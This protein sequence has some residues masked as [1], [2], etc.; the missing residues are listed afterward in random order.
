MRNKPDIDEIDIDDLYNNL[1]VYE[2]EMKKSSTSSSNT[3]NLAFISSENSGS[4]NTVNTAS[5]EHGVS[6]AAG[7]AFTSQVS[8]TPCTH[9]VSCSFFAHPTTSPQL[10]NEDFQQIDGDD[11]REMILR[12][13]WPCYSLGKGHFARECR[14]AKSQGRRPYGDR[15]NA[16][17]TESS[18]KALVAQDGLG[19]YDWS[20]DFEVEP[21]YDTER[22]KH[23]KAKLEIRGYEIALESL[24]ARILG[25]EKNELAWG[26]KYEFQ[27]YDLKCREIKINN[28]NTEL[29]KVVKERD[30]LKLKIE[31]WEGSSKNLT[32]ILNS[33][34]STHDKNGLGFGTQ[35]DDLSN[36]SETDS[37]NSLTVFETPIADISFAGLDE[38]AIRNKIIE[39]KTL[40]TTKTLGNTNDKNA[41]KPKSVNEKVVSKTGFNRDEVIIEDW[42]SDD[43]EDMC[44]VNTVSSVKPNV[45]QADKSARGGGEEVMWMDEWESRSLVQEHAVVDSGCCSHMNWQQS[46]LSDYERFT[47]RLCAFGSDPKG[48]K[49]M[50]KC[51]NKTAKI[52]LDDVY[53]YINLLDESQV[54]LRALK[55]CEYILEFKD[56]CSLGVEGKQHKASCKAKLDRIIRKPLELLHMDLSV[57]VSI[58]SINKK[59]VK[60]WVI[61]ERQRTRIPAKDVVQDA[62]EQPSENASPDKGIQVSEDVFD[63]EGQHQMPE[64]EQVW[65]DELEMMVTQELVA[66]AMNDESRQA[67]ERK[68]VRYA[69]QKKAAQATS[70]NQLSTDRPFVSTDRSNT[71]NV[72]AASTSTCANVD[73]SSFVYF[74]GKIPIDASTLPNVDLPIDPNMPDLEDASDTLP[75]NGIFNRAYDDD[76]DVGAVAD[77]NNMDNQIDGSL[78]QQ[79]KQRDDSTRFLQHK[80]SLEPNTISQALKDESWVEAMQEELLQFKLQQVWILV[81]LPFGKKAIGTKWVFRNKRDERSIVVK[82]KARLVLLRPLHL[83][84]GF[85]SI[86]AWLLKVLFFGINIRR[87]PRAWYETLSSF[88]LENG[89][90]R[91]T[92][93]KTLFIKKNKSDIMLVQVYVDDIIFGSTKKSMCTEFEEVMHKRFQ[94]SSMGELTFFLGLQVK[95][96]PDGIFISQDKYV[97]D[98]LKK[99][100]FCSIKTATTPIES[101]KPLVKDEDGVEVDVHEY[102]SMIGSLMYLTASRPDI[103][104]AVCACARFQ[105]T[106][107]ASHLHAVKRIFR[108]LKHQPKLGL[109]YPRDSPFELEAFSDSD[110]AGASLDRKSTTGGCQFLGRR[111]IS[112]QC[113]KQTIMANSTTEAEYVAAAHC[114]GQVLWIQ[115]QMM[116]YGFNFMNTKI[117]IDNEST[118]C[119]VKNP[120]Y[121][122]RTKHIEIRHHFIRDCYE[123]RLIDVLKI[124]TDSNVADLLTKGFDVTRISMDLRM[125]RCSAGKFYSSMVYLRYAL[126]HNPT[127]YDSLVKQFW[128][129]ATVRTLANGTQQLVAS[130]DSKEYNITEASVRSKLQLA[131]ATGIHNLSDAE[132][133]AGLATLGYVTEG[134]IVP[135]L[136]AML[137]GVAVDQ[138]EGSAQPAEP[139]HTPVD[140]ISSTSQPPIPSLLHQSPPHS[141]PH[142]PPYSPHPSPPLSPPHYSPPGSYEAPLPEGNTSGSAEDSMQLKELMVLVPKL[143]TRIG[144]LE[145]ELKETKQTLGNAVLKLVKKV[146]S[147]ETA[148]KRKSKKVIVSESE[149]E[150]SEDQGRKFQDID[151]DPLVSLVR[152]SMKEKSTDFVT[153]TKASGEAQ[154]EISPTILEAAKTLSKVA[155]QGVSKEKS[156]DKGKRYRRRARSMA[157]K[158]DT[159]LDAREEVNTGR[160]KINTGIEEVSTGSTKIDSGTASKRGQREG[161]A[162]MV[163]EDI[164]ATHKTKEQ[165]RQE[166]AG[167]EE[168]IKLQA[169]LDEEVAKQIHL[170]KM[171]AQRMAEEEAL[172]EQQKKRKAQVQ[173]E[174]QFYT[175]ED[176]DTIRAKLEANAELSKDVLGQDLPEQDFA[177]RMVDMV[178]QRKKHFAEERAKAKRNK[179]MTQSQLR[180]YMSNYLKNQGTWKLSQ[181]KKLKFEEIKEEFDKLVQQIDT[182]VP[183]ATKEKLKRYGEELQTKTSKKQKIND[184]DV[185]AI[186]EKVVEV[187]EEEQ[188]KR[189][190]KRKKQKA[191]KGINVDK[192]AQED[193]ETDK[194]ESVEAMNPTPLTTKSDSVVNWKIFQQGQRSVYQIIRENGAKTVYMSFGAMIKDF[195]REDLIELYRLVMQ[196]YGI[197]RPKDAYDRVLWSDLRT[198]FDP[199]LIEDAIWSLPLQQKMVSWRYYDKCEVHCLTLEACTIYM[200]ADRKYPLSKEACQVMLKMK[201]LDGKMNEVCY[202]LLKMI[203]KQAGIRNCEEKTKT[204]RQNDYVVLVAHPAPFRKFPEPFL[205]LVRMSRYYT[206][207]E[208]TYLSFLHDDKTDMDLFAF[209]QVVNPTKMRVVGRER[210]KGE[211]KLLDFT[212]IAHKFANLSGKGNNEKGWVDRWRS[213]F[214]T[215][216]KRRL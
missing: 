144:S 74:G 107:K 83:I 201:L 188:V 1:R 198:M 71:P 57:P 41:K 47:M 30:E 95:Q 160:E 113:K 55:R 140:P 149:S 130:I 67:F 204:K 12:C 157:K 89:F 5:G 76:E 172:T 93:D 215:C 192:S 128:Q 153:P 175:E 141:P 183:E 10:E 105:V 116:D 100:D 36:K 31:K 86:S 106:P 24:E 63:K 110:Y 45:T 214:G 26:E 136:P 173:F 59:S 38:Y 171:I 65:Q 111:L 81:D 34:M 194:E 178:N 17:T 176:W 60:H 191:R 104:F 37:E 163:E 54:V 161:K 180:I 66:N 13:R 151:D 162:P 44:P 135:L 20:N 11:F 156:T 101:N 181:L 70:T 114:C 133:Y 28:L 58:E 120:V 207:D 18:S 127:I 33:Q 170:D 150:E 90:R 148:L 56:N 205:C 49:I 91:G 62:Q 159:G 85:L 8:S 193:S 143:V 121:H 196:K 108:Y 147:L 131:D 202:K 87:V 9:D 152:E 211:E 138:G 213:E 186:G 51:K 21:N 164:Q 50:G 190:G 75:N 200:L 197:N 195:T 22:E 210:T 69:S 124:H 199:P 166:E 146:K 102:R 118:I 155:S 126:T 80:T 79:F 129:T 98:I 78:H 48:C 43:E 177:K 4:T 158:I 94:M 2:D 73:E 46:Y 209:I 189:T 216:S 119:V 7:T 187:K 99:F 6:A 3:Q 96:Q 137:A 84:R 14:S 139:Q 112:W 19:G 40:E 169:Q 154:E 125:D 203:E 52:G 15:S 212:A 64:D 185:P 42:T 115:N 182:F 168:A 61:V 27:N 25:H 68:V 72:S 29:E 165:L 123:K 92:I 53:F 134:D 103:M 184:K 117:H 208:D 88:L 77:F 122:S 109:W 132:I 145:K 167:L 142:S 97:A 206:L 39:S 32:K 16:Q 35:M 174:A 179:P 82:N 23:N